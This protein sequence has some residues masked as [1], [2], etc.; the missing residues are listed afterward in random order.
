[1]AVLVE[2][3]GDELALFHF[4]VVAQRDGNLLVVPLHDV[5]GHFDDLFAG[6]VK[7]QIGTQLVADLARLGH[8]G[9]G[10]S[11][12]DLVSFRQVTCFVCLHLFDGGFIETFLLGDRQADTQSSFAI[13]VHRATHAND[14]GGDRVEI[15]HAHDGGLPVAERLAQRRRGVGS[16]CDAGDARAHCGA[17]NTVSQVSAMRWRCSTTRSA[18]TKST[19]A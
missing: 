11:E 4:E 9:V 19:V 15:R 5:D 10:E 18:E 12:G 14:F 3:E 8:D 2:D 17:P 1:M 16:G 6:E 13:V 7:E